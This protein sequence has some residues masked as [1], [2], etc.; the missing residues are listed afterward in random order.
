MEATRAAI[1]AALPP[2]GPAQNAPV[3]IYSKDTLSVSGEVTYCNTHAA[4]GRCH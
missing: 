3:F 2:G 4:G 1:L